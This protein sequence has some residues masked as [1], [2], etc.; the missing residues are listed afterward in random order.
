MF[1]E[2]IYPYLLVASQFFCLI[3]VFTTAP[4][5]AS[6]YAGILV[7]SLGVFMGVLAIFTMGIGNF[8]VAPLNKEDGSLVTNGIYKFIRHPMYI[9]QLLAI[10]PLLIDY[11]SYARIAVFVLL[12]ITLLLKISFEESHLV[13][14]FEGYKDYQK[15][16]WKLIPYIY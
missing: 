6:G 5:I 15:T 8:N 3:F 11:F 14:H 9:G 2:K 1:K 16:S 7:E 10:L 13:T 4:V 12:L